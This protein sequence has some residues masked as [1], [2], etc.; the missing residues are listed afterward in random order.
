[1][2]NRLV[3]NVEMMWCQRSKPAFLC[4]ARLIDICSQRRCLSLPGSLI[5]SSD[6]ICSRMLSHADLLCS[7]AP[8]QCTQVINKGSDS[9]NRWLEAFA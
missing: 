4:S 6:A 7:S 5:S 1:M 8:A 2:P 3:N 9:E